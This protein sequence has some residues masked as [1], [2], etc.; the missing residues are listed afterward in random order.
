MKSMAIR[1]TYS[2]HDFKDDVS[3]VDDMADGGEN[4]SQ[5]FAEMSEEIPEPP[6]IS[7]IILQFVTNMFYK[8]RQSHFRFS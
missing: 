2:K 6:K 3:Q 7:F 1:K 8:L 4:K 5:S